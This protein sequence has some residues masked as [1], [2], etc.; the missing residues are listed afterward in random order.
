VLVYAEAA[1][2]Q[3][4]QDAA[5]ATTVNTPLALALCISKGECIAVDLT[6]KT[7]AHNRA[8]L[9]AAKDAGASL[10]QVEACLRADDAD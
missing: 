6:D 10:D 7:P 2:A 4:L 1:V 8:A 5:R 3:N 9:V